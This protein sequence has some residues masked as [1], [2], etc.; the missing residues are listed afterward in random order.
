M[1]KYKNCTFEIKADVDKREVEAYASIFD[2]KDSYDD[3]MQKGAFTKTIKENIRRIKTLWN[4]NWDNPIGK[5]LRIEED[6]KGLYTV[7][8]FAK[9]SKADEILQLVKENVIDEL[10][11]GYT[12][13]KDGYDKN[14]NANLLKEV[15]LMEYSFVTF[16]ANEEAQVTGVK[17]LDQYLNMI[18][19]FDIN[20]L[21]QD[22][23]KQAI[24]ALESLLIDV[25]PTQVTQK[26]I[27][28]IIEDSYD[29]LLNELKQLQQL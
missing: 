5:P 22:K 20:T 7:T 15:K 16:A 2:N 13:V 10:S 29:K 26:Q 19:N 9:T 17:N 21:D 1:I 3:I 27:E 25:E 8:K 18:N 4:H 23:I 14:K 11:I 12:T 6:S 24:K 28:P